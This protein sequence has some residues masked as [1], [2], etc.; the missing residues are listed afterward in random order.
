M[1]KLELI[2]KYVSSLFGR[3]ITSNPKNVRSISYVNFC[4]SQ[5]P[6]FIYLNDLKSS[7]NSTKLIVLSEIMRFW[8][9]LKQ[10]LPRPC[11]DLLLHAL[12]SRMKMLKCA[13][14]RTKSNPFRQCCWSHTL[15]VLS[16]FLRGLG[17]TVGETDWSQSC[18]KRRRRK[19]KRLA[20]QDFY[21]LRGRKVP[22]SRL[23][24][25]QSSQGK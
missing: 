7:T 11:H 23:L 22:G 6:F 1:Q 19:K 14:E 21:W 3:P 25:I 13:S 4:Y 24:Q 5:T 15:A 10:P 8:K 16:L 17:R 18:W 20:I 12:K 2:H 9:P